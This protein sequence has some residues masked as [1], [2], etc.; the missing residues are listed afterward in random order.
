LISESPIWDYIGLIA[1]HT[2]GTT[3]ADVALVAEITE[4]YITQRRTIC[5]AVVS[6]TSDYAN[7]MILEKVRQVDPHGERTLGIIT[8]PDR[9]DAGSG[10]EKAFIELANNKDVFFQLGWH[11][12]KNRSYTGESVSIMNQR[13]NLEDRLR[14]WKMARIFSDV[15][16]KVADEWFDAI[17]WIGYEQ[18]ACLDYR[19]IEITEKQCDEAI[20]QLFVAPSFDFVISLSWVP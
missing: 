13:K 7:Q 6:A 11:G 5:L 20:S 19:L 3:S 18:V 15:S 8:K 14:S 9:L 1:T 2:E 10:S 12:L 17:L 16:C 4:Q